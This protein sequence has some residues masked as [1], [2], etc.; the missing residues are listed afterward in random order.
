MPRIVIGIALLLAVG[1]VP[2]YSE[3][4]SGQ[5]RAQ[6]PSTVVPDKRP[7][8]SVPS[9]GVIQ[10]APDTSRDATVRPPNVDPG[11]A[12]SP[13]GTPGGDPKVDPK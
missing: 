2:A 9:S 4:P 1:F 10:P 8:S 12:I 13:P 6:T 5:E 7:D 3:V 11:M